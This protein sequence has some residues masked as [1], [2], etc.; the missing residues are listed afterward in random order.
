M[1][2][3]LI[4]GGALL[5]ALI[6]IGLIFARLYQRATKEISFVRTGL[7]GQKVLINGGCIVLPILHEVIPVNMNTLRLEVQRSNGQAL[8]TRD[9]MRVD[10]QA[11]FYVRVQ[12]TTDSIANA[13]QTLGLKT[14]QPEL[15]K[16]LVE[17]KF[18]DALRAV[19][20][21]MTMEELSGAGNR[22][23]NR[24]RPD[25]ARVL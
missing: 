1:M 2:S 14:T 6:T 17:G 24:P 5:V 8:I 9:R 22:L 21:E 7:G 4:I 12:P 18:V 13:A 15:L 20:A 25:Q 3:I 16:E 10:V 23:A 11:E 19:A